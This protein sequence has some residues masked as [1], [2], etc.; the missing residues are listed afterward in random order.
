MAG[1][2]CLF[3]WFFCGLAEVMATCTTFSH[4]YP[5]FKKACSLS[6]MK[7]LNKDLAALESLNSIS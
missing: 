2:S 6:K 7:C 1:F 5:F 3:V 4:L